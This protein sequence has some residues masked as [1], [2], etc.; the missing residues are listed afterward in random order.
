[1]NRWIAIAGLVVLAASARIAWSHDAT[2]T[3]HGPADNY[4]YELAKPGTYELPRIKRA[5]G[6]ELL[7]EAGRPFDLGAHLGSHLTLLAFV[8]TR[9]G[10]VC[11]LA[12]MHMAE[13]RDMAAQRPELASTVRLITL[14]F[15]PGFDTPR[16]M[17]DYADTWRGEARDAPQWSFLTASSTEALRPI[18]EAY[19]QPVAPKRDAGDPGGPLNHLMRA[20]LIDGDGF[21]RNIYSADFLDARLIMND[22]LTLV[23]DRLPVE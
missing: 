7:D 15:D 11:P 17:A 6:G 13:F 3:V 18:L 23:D 14:S 19:D 2:G 5:G 9:C 8:Y 4:V 1:M 10:D 21:V 20:F 22:L 12:T 16:I